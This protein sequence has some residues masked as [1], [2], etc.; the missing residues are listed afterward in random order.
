MTVYSVRNVGVF[1]GETIER[2][3]QLCFQGSPGNILPKDT[4][5]RDDIDG[6]N[7]TLLPG[8]IDSKIDGGASLLILQQSAA[9]GVTTVI[10][11]SS[12]TAESLAM[13]TTSSQNVG[14]PSYLATAVALFSRST[15]AWQKK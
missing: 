2:P 1:N 6:T 5:A 13:R 12:G 11:S 4:E 8:F 10:D 7:C 9:F 14:M 15:V 3:T